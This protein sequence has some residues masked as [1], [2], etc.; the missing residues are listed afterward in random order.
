[1]LAGCVERPSLAL[2]S[3]LCSAQSAYVFCNVFQDGHERQFIFTFC[4]SL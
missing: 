4:K 2:L 1:M 3:I